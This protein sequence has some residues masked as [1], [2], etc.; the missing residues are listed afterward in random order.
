MVWAPR[1]HK[2]RLTGYQ[3]VEP[4]A[5]RGAVASAQPGSN[6]PWSRPRGSRDNVCRLRHALWPS[7]NEDAWPSWVS[8]S[9]TVL[10]SRTPCSP[11]KQLAPIVDR[12]GIDVVVLCFVAAGHRVFSKDRVVTDARRDRCRLARPWRGSRRSCRL[13][14]RANGDRCCRRGRRDR[15]AVLM[16]RIVLHL[17]K[18]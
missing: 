14:H 4:A 18:T 3:R 5:E 6:R 15:R 11:T 8:S 17:P 9:I 16:P 13:W 2:N 10:M 7:C 1:S 12:S